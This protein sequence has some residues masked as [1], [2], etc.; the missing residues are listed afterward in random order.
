MK[1]LEFESKDLFRSFGVPVP[2]T[3]GVIRKPEELPAALKKAGKA[4]WVIKAQ[5]LAGG[6]GKA[7]GIKVVKTPEAAAEAVT[8]ML[9]KG[10]TTHQ[11]SGQ[12]LKVEQI[13]IDGGADIKKEFYVSFVIDRQAGGPAMIAS[14]EGGVEIEKLAEERPEAILRQ[15]FEPTG[16]LDYQA[17]QMAF[18]L[19]V[20]NDRINE[21][22]GI[23]KKL[24]RVF[25]DKDCSMVEVNPLALTPEGFIALDGKV[26][27]DDSANFRQK[28]FAARVDIEASALE[29]EANKAALS[30]V[31]LDGD[32]GCMVNGAG[33]A[34]GTMDTIKLAG[35]N[36]ANFLDVGG[37][38]DE[39]RVTK[40]FNIILGDKR[41]KAVLVNIFGGIVKCD[42][43]AAGILGAI[44]NVSLKIPLIVR[45]EGTNVEAGRKLLTESGVSLIQ[46]DNLWTAAQKAVEAAK[47]GK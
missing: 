9:G 10:L 31:G 24:A 37:G 21:F 15:S 42:M 4:P 29:L 17:R 26:V 41:V 3:G 46:A 20:S 13:L 47:G 22:C 7:G 38:A 16:L 6:R 36:P 40:A 30:Y 45:L 11:T 27:T 23:L 5:V 28:D 43:I 14:A 35:G 18:G 44:K 19:G 25:L 12:A 8:T 39:E 33:L 34:M 1:L 32:I 2:Q